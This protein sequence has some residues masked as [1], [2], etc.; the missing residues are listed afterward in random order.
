MGYE[1]SC[2]GLS[3]RRPLYTTSEPAWNLPLS[4]RLIPFEQNKNSFTAQQVNDL[5][6]NK[7]LPFQE[8]LT[9][10]VL[11][12]NYSSPEYI[13]DTYGQ[14]NLVNIARL[15]SSRNVWKKLSE[16]EQQ[17]RREQ[18]EDNRGATAIYGDEYKLSQASEWKLPSDS[19]DCFGIKL[20]NGKHCLVEI[21]IW[22]DMMIRTK[23]GK[24]MKDKPFRL[25]RIKLVDPVTQQPIFKKELWLGLWGE[26]KGELTGEEIYWAYRNRYDIEHFFRFGK[27]RLLLDKYQTPDEEHLQNW[28]EVVSLAYWLL[29]AGKEQAGYECPKWQKYDKNLKKRREYDLPPSPSQVQR[30]MESIIWGFEQD[31][32]LPKVQI[33]GKG[34]Q[35]GQTLPKRQTYPVLKKQKKQPMPLKE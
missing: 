4:L 35:E 8:E 24:N 9:V 19:Q 25:V 5:L 22:D 17:Q 34:R 3:G 16:E 29:W 28:L 14:A 11:D 31:P 6:N 10:N 23:R 12:S 18:N 15:K 33:K 27:Q 2:V 20:S 30:Q 7:D 1:F 13:A 26:R 21:D 32:F